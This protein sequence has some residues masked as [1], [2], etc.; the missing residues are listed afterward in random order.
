MTDSVCYPYPFAPRAG[1]G[2]ALS[3]P[4]PCPCLHAPP[5]LPSP[6]GGRKT[7]AATHHPF[8]FRPKSTQHTAA[9]LIHRGKN[10]RNSRGKNQTIRCDRLPCSYKQNRKTTT[11]RYLLPTKQEDKNGH[12]RKWTRQSLEW[13]C[14][15]PRRK[16]NV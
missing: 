11:P 14:R 12:K 9:S 10:R 2:K 4:C 5:P 15:V 13:S 16:K 3:L 6:T 8:R 7:V 1:R